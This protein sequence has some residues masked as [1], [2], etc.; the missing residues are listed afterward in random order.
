M[1]ALKQNLTPKVANNGDFKEGDKKRMH[2]DSKNH[3]KHMCA[4]K[5]QELTDCIIILSDK[6]V[7]T[8]KH[9]GAKANS[10]HNICAAHLGAE[11]PNIEGG[12]GFVSLDEIGKPHAGKKE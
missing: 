6:P 8:C 7:V 1:P 5:A 10:V 12:H 2:C 11:A 9:C 4:L 3:S